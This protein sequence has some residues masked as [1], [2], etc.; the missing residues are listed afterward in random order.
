[1]RRA[2]NAKGRRGFL[3]PAIIPTQYNLTDTNGEAPFTA[4]SPRRTVANTEMV[5]DRQFYCKRKFFGTYNESG[6]CMAT[7][8]RRS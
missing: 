5:A 8:A 6:V 1:M 3:H 2:E 7:T 4:I